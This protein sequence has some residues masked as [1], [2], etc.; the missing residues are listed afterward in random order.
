VSE[1]ELE[2]D[3]L[4][5]LLQGGKAVSALSI[6]KTLDKLT[7]LHRRTDLLEK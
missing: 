7:Y 4:V 6:K 1:E 2:D 5:S 3:D